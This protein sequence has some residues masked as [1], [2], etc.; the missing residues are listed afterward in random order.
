MRDNIYEPISGNPNDPATKEDIAHLMK[1][2]ESLFEQRGL[3]LVA[4]TETK[5]IFHSFAPNFT[6]SGKKLNN[7]KQ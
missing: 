6:V 5:M 7:N 4:V 3:T 1:A 2:F